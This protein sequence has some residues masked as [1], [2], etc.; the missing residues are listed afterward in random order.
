MNKKWTTKDFPVGIYQLNKDQSVNFQMNRFFNWSNDQVM[1][2]QM[3]TIGGTDQTYTTLI[4]DF[5]K[6][7]QTALNENEK[8]RAALYFRAA[9][10][11]LPE[12]DKNKKKLREQ[13]ISLNNE[14]YGISD[15]QHFLIPYQNGKLS[16]YRVAPEKPRGTILFINGFDGYIEELTRMML[17]YRDA[18]YEVIYFDGPGQGYV[19]ENHQIPM[20]SQWEKPVKAVLDYFKVNDA[21]AIGMSLGGNLVLRAAAF[22]KRIKKVVCFDILPSLFK[23]VTR[24]L[25]APL[26]KEVEEAIAGHR[27]KLAL[28]QKLTTLMDQSL[29][30]QWAFQQGMHVMGVKSPY[31]FVECSSRYDSSSISKLV[32]Q[33][34]LLLSGQAD[35]YVPTDQLPLQISTLTNVRSL[36]ARLFTA[37][38]SAANHCQLGNIG[39]AVSTILKWLD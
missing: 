20:T 9:E 11:Y 27:D 34:V 31:A 6:L 13:F 25:P 30:V 10:F 7:G 26:K 36:T 39:L 29:M 14:F 19:L 28:N 17:V 18:G 37:K 8:L 4:A 38:E 15:K 16:A 12:D 2:D 21:I 32:D 3:K 33:D 35:H 23:C 22:E 24:Q 1:L 5:E